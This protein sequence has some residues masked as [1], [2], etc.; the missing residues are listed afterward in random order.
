[1]PLAVK[2]DLLDLAHETVAT[3]A[4]RV[5]DGDCSFHCQLLASIFYEAAKLEL[6]KTSRDDAQRF[7]LLSAVLD[8]C[9]RAAHPRAAPS[10]I[11]ERLRSALAMMQADGRSMPASQRSFQKTHRFRVIQGGLSLAPS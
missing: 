3:V 5:A 11:L 9:G 1:M 8:Q 6:N 2:T 10:M 4:R 7:E